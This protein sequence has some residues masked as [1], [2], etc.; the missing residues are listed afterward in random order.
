MTDKKI[1][2]IFDEFKRDYT[3]P[4]DSGSSKVITFFCLYIKRQDNKIQQQFKD[5]FIRELAT[6]TYNNQSW[7]IDVLMRLND[8]KLIPAIYDIF[9]KYSQETINNVNVYTI[10]KIFLL[11]MTLKDCDNNHVILYYNFVEQE[12]KKQIFLHQDAFFLNLLVEYLAVNPQH[13]LEILSDYYAR[14]ISA[15]STRNES[16]IFIPCLFFSQN[17]CVHMKDFLTMTYQK[18]PQSGIYLK[19]LFVDFAKYHPA[20]NKEEWNNM[21]NMVLHLNSISLL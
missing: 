19:K 20:E 13:S 5:F 6:N 3:I 7:A 11:L 9:Y 14:F 15:S 16:N 1:L 18:N 17:S 2:E 4:K 21:Q 8:P 12:V 10:G